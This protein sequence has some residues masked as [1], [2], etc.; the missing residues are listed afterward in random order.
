MVSQGSNKQLECLKERHGEIIKPELGT[1]KGETAK[2]QL[3]D[4]AKSVFQKARP[5]PY[6]LRLA[7]EEELKRLESEGVWSR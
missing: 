4:N 2:M 7:V 1:V 3:K 5:V 6:A